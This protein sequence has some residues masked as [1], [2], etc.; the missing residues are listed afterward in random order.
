[1]D[2][3][4]LVL[5]TYPPVHLCILEPD[6]MNQADQAPPPTYDEVTRAPGTPQMPNNN[7]YSDQ[8]ESSEHHSPS[9]PLLTPGVQG[10]NSYS[11][12]P[13]PPPRSYASSVS[14]KCGEVPL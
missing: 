3:R 5:T 2:E 1:M 9:A 12:I 7:S 13:P 4:S 14:C 6:T 8:P 10:S 11:S